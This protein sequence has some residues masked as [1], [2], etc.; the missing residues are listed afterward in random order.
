MAPRVIEQ[1]LA[2]VDPLKA[3]GVGKSAGVYVRLGHRFGRAKDPQRE[4]LEKLSQALAELEQGSKGADV[5][6]IG[7]RR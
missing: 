4:A 1:I 7:G 2:H 3:E 6:E 5:I